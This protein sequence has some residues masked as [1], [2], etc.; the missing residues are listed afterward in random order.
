MTIAL[1]DEKSAVP[2]RNAILL[3]LTLACG[4]VL[5]AFL[6]SR[7]LLREVG[8]VNSY[9][10]LA[11][12]FLHGRLFIDKCPE[13]D[14]AN[15]NGETYVIFPPLPA[16]V[17][18]PFVALFGFKKF[19]GFIFLAMALATLSLFLWRSIFRKLDVAPADATWL[20]LALAFASPLFQIVVRADGVWFFAQVVAFLMMTGAIWAVVCCRSFF[21]AGLFIGGAFLCRQMA[22]FYVLFFAALAFEPTDRLPSRGILRR[23]LILGLPVVAALLLILVYNAARFGSPL[24]TGYA[25]IHNVDVDNFIGHR[26]AD[27]GL[28][29][30]HYLLFNLVYL[31]VQGPHFEFTGPYLT[32]LTGIDKSGVALAITSPWLL[33][34]FYSKIDRVLFAGLATIAIIAGLTLFY[35]SNGAEQI[36]TQRYVLDWLPIAVFLMVRGP[37]PALFDALP[38]LVTWGVVTNTFIVALAA[39]YKL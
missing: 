31:F 24:D 39:L 1:S 37:R 36:N 17:A 23:Q 6:A 2:R 34:A 27:L 9:G 20:L 8:G 16:I 11:D 4:F 25:Y 21:L 12:A 19:A 26:I 38:I 33:L 3:W 22:I 18:L 30:R 7:G 14:C 15:F 5:L 28:F 10:A 32:Q 29:S 35:H 13:I